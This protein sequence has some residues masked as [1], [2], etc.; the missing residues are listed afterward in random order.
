MRLVPPRCQFSLQQ[1][2]FLAFASIEVGATRQIARDPA[3]DQAVFDNFAGKSRCCRGPSTF[4]VLGGKRTRAPAAGSIAIMSQRHESRR[5]A[6]FGILL[7]LVAA[8]C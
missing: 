6:N 1:V 5:T 8:G 3:M 4:T 2:R 7:A